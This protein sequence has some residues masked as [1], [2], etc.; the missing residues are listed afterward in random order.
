LA[1]WSQKHCDY[2]II[3]RGCHVNLEFVDGKQVTVTSEQPVSNAFWWKDFV[4]VS[5]RSNWRFIISK[6]S[7]TTKRC[8]QLLCV[9]SYWSAWC[10][11]GN[12]IVAQKQN[13]TFVFY[14][15]QNDQEFEVQI[16]KEMGDE[17]DDCIP[18][19]R[20]CLL[21]HG[22]Q[23]YVSRGKVVQIF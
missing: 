22:S 2:K 1:G 16:A 4:L 21:A 3:L 18:R 14:D 6:I 10:L 9:P 5:I 7:L 19:G 8:E 13:G 20:S 12:M 15:L 23:L 11:W 17:A